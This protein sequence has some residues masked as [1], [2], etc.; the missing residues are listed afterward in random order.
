ML[1]AEAL[2]R[3]R[4]SSR[5]TFRIKTATELDKD[6]WTLNTSKEDHIIFAI[7]TSPLIFL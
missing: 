6:T 2:V 7:F 4:N 1:T 5:Q 3:L